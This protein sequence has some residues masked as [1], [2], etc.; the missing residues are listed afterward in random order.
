MTEKPQPNVMCLAPG[1]HK[2]HYTT[3]AGAGE[4][5]PWQEPVQ[6]NTLEPRNKTISAFHVSP[7]PSAD[8]ASVA[9]CKETI[10][11]RPQVHFY[12]AIKNSEFGAERQ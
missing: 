12:G 11:K 2:R 5:F 7:V 3:A 8:K 6:E 4:G 9:A 1:G 10:L